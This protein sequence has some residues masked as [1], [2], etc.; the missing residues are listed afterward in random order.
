MD[1]RL[2]GET[3]IISGPAQSGKASLLYWALR[4]DER[5]QIVSVDC[6]L[7]RTEMQFIQKLTREIGEQIGLKGLDKKAIIQENIKFSELNGAIKESDTP[8][9]ILIRNAERLVEYR[10][11]ILLYNI[12]EWVATDI[13]KY[14]GLVFTTRLIYF[15]DR[16]EKR[17]RSRLAARTIALG[18]P[19]PENLIILLARRIETAIEAGRESLTPRTLEILENVGEIVGGSKKLLETIRDLQERCHRDIVCYLN[20]M[21]L[22]FSSFDHDDHIYRMDR[23]RLELE[24][25]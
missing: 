6:A 16:F 2:I 10:K 21:K 12:L 11:Q 20:A 14:V 7:H 22:V 24:L 8:I 4:N 25:C 18:R 19:S 5:V 23:R 13:K 9:V 3:Y 17:V 1:G 15:V